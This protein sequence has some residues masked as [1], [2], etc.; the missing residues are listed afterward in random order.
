MRWLRYIS[1][2]QTPKALRVFSL[3]QM[4]WGY[5]VE[6]APV[7]WWDRNI[8]ALYLDMSIRDKYL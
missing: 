8:F 6:L 1:Q 7:T 4:M 5:R 2:P 3:A